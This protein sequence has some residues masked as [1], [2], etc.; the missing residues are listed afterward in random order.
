MLSLVLD[1]LNALFLTIVY[2]VKGELELKKGAFAG[3]FGIAACIGAM[4]FQKEFLT[5][6][7]NRLKSKEIFYFLFLF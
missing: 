6:N 4:F 5:D 3:I 1:F 2:G 7:S